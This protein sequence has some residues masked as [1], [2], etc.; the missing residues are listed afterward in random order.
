MAPRKAT[1]AA[2]PGLASPPGSPPLEATVSTVDPYPEPKDSDGDVLMPDQAQNDDVPGPSTTHIPP[3]TEPGR[4][5]SPP[6][7]SLHTRAF[8]PEEDEDDEDDEVLATLPVYMSPA[9]FPTL[10]LFQYPL[11]TETLEPPKYAQDRNKFITTRIKEHVGRVEVE[12]PVDEDVNYWRRERAEELGFVRDVNEDDS[13]VVGGYGF[14][15]RGGDK[16]KD[17]SK[18]KKKDKSHWGEKMRLRSEPIPNETGYY[19]GVIQDGESSTASGRQS[20]SFSLGALFLHPVTRV[21]Q[22]R[23]SLGYL[24]DFDERIRNR[25]AR[26]KGEETED[27]KAKP[28]GVAQYPMPNRAKKVCPSYIPRCLAQDRG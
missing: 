13:G 6:L 1:A 5:L 9:L 24:D 4:P 11:R 25:A 21:S 2:N 8:P 19:S 10:N 7:P 14:G 22:F 3:Q 15:G 28:N 16:D 17:K 27:K 20:S 26:R 23:T 12:L 18:S